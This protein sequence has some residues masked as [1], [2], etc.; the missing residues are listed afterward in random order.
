M[1]RRCGRLS[2]GRW[3]ANFTPQTQR[4]IEI[5]TSDGSFSPRSRAATISALQARI[6][7]V[8]IEGAFRDVREQPL[9]G[10]LKGGAS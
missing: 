1:C 3:L 6:A 9:P 4:I 7:A 2:S 5:G 10:F 8:F